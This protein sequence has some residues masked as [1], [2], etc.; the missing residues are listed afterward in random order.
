[1][2][3][4][5]RSALEEK[6]GDDLSILGLA[7]EVT[8]DFERDVIQVK[9]YLKRHNVSYPVLVAGLSDKKLASKSVPFLDKVRSYPTTIFVNSKQEVISIHT[10]FS[11]PATGKEYESLKRKFDE[12]IDSMIAQSR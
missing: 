5:F 6:Y 12:L 7:F 10:G 8:G 9:R 11:G 3:D 2:A 1:M 4:T